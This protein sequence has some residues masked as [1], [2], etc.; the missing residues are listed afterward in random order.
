VLVGL[1]DAQELPDVQVRWPDGREETWR[2]VRIDGYSTLI[3]GTG[4]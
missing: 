3:Q 4:Q 2:R 1:G